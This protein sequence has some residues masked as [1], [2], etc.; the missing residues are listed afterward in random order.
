MNRIA[1]EPPVAAQPPVL[2]FGNCELRAGTREL[3]VDGRPQALRRR[4]FDLMLYLIAHRARVVPHAELLKEVW[5]RPSVSSKMLARA[6]ME[7]RRACGDTAQQ[8]AFFAS[9]HGVGYRFVGQLR[10]ASVAPAG[11]KPLAEPGAAGVL[12]L[13]Q[14]AKAARDAG[15]F[16]EAQLLAERALVLAGQVPSPTA[17]VQAL[18]L[19][20]ALTLRRGTAGA[21]ARLAAQALQ[22]AR[23]EGSDQLEAQARL[24]LGCVHVAAGDSALG[25]RYLQAAHEVLRASGSP[26]DL[27]RCKSYMAAAFRDKSNAQSGLR[28]CRDSL[29]YAISQNATQQILAERCNE[30][31]FLINLGEQLEAE[32]HAAQARATYEE[33][34]ALVEAL[35]RDIA[36]LGAVNR[37]EPALGNRASLLEKLGRVDEA[38]QAMADLEQAMDLSAG[39]G[40]PVHAERQQMFLTLKAILLARSGRYAE[41]LQHIE[42]CIEVAQRP[43]HVSNLPWMYGVASD[44]AERAGR[45]G[46]ALTWAR[47]QTAA[48]AAR[49]ASDAAQLVRILEAE[50]NIEDVQADLERSRHQ[51]ATLLQENAALRQQAQAMV[52]ALHVSPLTG[53]APESSLGAAFHGPHWQA[54]AR[55]LPMCL[56]LLSLNGALLARMQHAPELLLAF[57]KRAAEV[58]R[59]HADIAYPA[60]EVGAG[61]LVFHIRDAG[62]LRAAEV[63]RAVAA[64]LHRQDWNPAEPGSAPVWQAHHL[65][66]ALLESV[67]SVVHQLR[68]RAAAQAS[69]GAVAGPA[70]V[71]S[72]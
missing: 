26:E 70:A 61:Q 19:C 45:C 54:R 63:C 49:H 57:H 62:L 41:A 53:L 7:A 21:A 18:A 2:C 34:L 31:V 32:R 69:P 71:A 66:G 58:L 60:V 28:L 38:W 42:G 24:A 35:I 30:I 25:L 48:Q 4:V 55:G 10:D 9:V 50:R 1:H 33:G 5:P 20:S 6:M 11:G 65:D 68:A 47:Q 59:N 16:D 64:Q 15:R 56:G 14:Q 36:E 3:L 12:D 52:G 27:M 40:S 51:V 43:G 13:L 8:P 46:L 22:V 23:A 67:D 37:R 17:R 39:A 44:L 29:A 72:D